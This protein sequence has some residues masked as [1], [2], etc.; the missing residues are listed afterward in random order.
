MRARS[1]AVAVGTGVLIALAAV[2][3]GCGSP[4]VVVARLP[5]TDAGTIRCNVAG[6]DAG[7]AGPGDGD[8]GPGPGDAGVEPCPRGTICVANACGSGIGTCTTPP[9]ACDDGYAPVCGCDGV[10][11][12]NDCLRQSAS[13]Q[14]A[15]QETCFF[16]GTTVKTCSKSACPTP[17]AGKSACAAFVDVGPGLSFSIDMDGGAS[18]ALMSEETLEDDLLCYFASTLLDNRQATQCW[19]LPKTAPSGATA[20]LREVNVQSCL[21]T[22]ATSVLETKCVDPYE[23][24]SGGG[25]FVEDEAR[26]ASGDASATE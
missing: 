14:V 17:G 15:A 25:L 4:D 6:F 11:Y 19:V 13:V 2:G 23:A 22:P 1:A 20:D 12:F 10:S 8:A 9:T 26:C 18:P 7:G 24:I 3:P 16:S 21:D 5:M